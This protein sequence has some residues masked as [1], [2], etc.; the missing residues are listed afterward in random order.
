MVL[1]ASVYAPLI[2]ALRERFPDIARRHGFVILDLTIYEVCNAIWKGYI[3]LNKISFN[4]AVNACIAVRTLIRW[5]EVYKFE[6]L[7]FKKV[8]EIAL[9]SSITVYDAAY[10]ALAIV[11]RT[12]IA[13][14]DEDIIKTAPK[15]SV[16]VV[17]LHELLV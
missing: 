13:S 15:Y 17:R 8:I 1:D 3:K 10:I 2:I 12:R 5:L 9:E 7:D 16:D 11:L 4:E 14:E 6:D